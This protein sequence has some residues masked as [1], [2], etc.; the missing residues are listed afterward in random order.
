MLFLP[1]SAF[2]LDGGAWTVSPGEWYSEVSASR[3]YASSR[4]LAD[5]RNA[6]LPAQGRFQQFDAVSY[7]EIGWLKDLSF[8]LAVPFSSRSVRRGSGTETVS[9]LSD[10]EIGLRYR[11]RPD[12]PGLVFEGAWQAPAGYNKYLD[13]RLGDGRQK[14]FG[15]IHA[16]TR[17]PGV[18]GFVQA[19]RGFFFV[20]EDGELYWRTR[21]E[22]GVWVGSRVLVGGRYADEAPL[23]SANEIATLGHAYRAGSVLLVRLDDQFDLSAGADRQVA[24]RNVLEGTRFHVTL[25]FKQTK[26]NPMQGFLGGS[27]KP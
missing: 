18:P 15:A 25:G 4:F 10:L 12:A 23:S 5:S 6:A 7:S 21:V 27:R 24:G 2:A 8:A 17:L 14:F 3:L 1:V 9:G 19:S 13:P 22:A 11:L 16:G 20:S 26:L